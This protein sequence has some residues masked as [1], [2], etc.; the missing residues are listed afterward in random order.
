[1]TR[2]LPL[3]LVLAVAVP[4]TALGVAGAAPPS[5]THCVARA[6]PGCTPARLIP[7]PTGVAASADG[8]VVVR[9]GVGSLG[10][11]GVFALDRRTGRLRQ[12]AGRAGCVARRTRVCMPGRGLETPAAAAF[13]PV[14]RS[15]Y[16]AAANGATL[17]HYRR[18]ASGALVAAGC[19]GSGLGCRPVR[20]LQ[21]PRDIELWIDGSTLYLAAARVIAFARDANGMLR[22]LD[23][24]SFRAS[25]VALDGYDLYAVGGGR[26]GGTLVA[27]RRAPESGLLDEVQRVEA[28]EV[29]ALRRPV[30]VVATER[31][32]YVASEGSGG[33]AVFRRDPDTA[34][35]AFVSCVTAGGTAPCARASGLAGIRAVAVNPTGT[36]LYVAAASTRAGGLGVYAR[37]AATGE[38]RQ[39]RLIRSARGMRGPNGVAVDPAGRHV[40]VTSEA[41]VAVFRR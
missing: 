39:V 14:G 7:S 29:P 19:W 8:A 32:V 30:D 31:H 24:E 38:L 15:V 11:L 1:M 41:G 4:A 37:N 17:A 33:I 13:S 28:T 5:Q 9:S 34:R 18:A 20:G 16:V 25:A 6:T 12:L 40:L 22:E 27:Y 35:L 2:L 21:A 26:S 36:H 10:T 3:A 23:S